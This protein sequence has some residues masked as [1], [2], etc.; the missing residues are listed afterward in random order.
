[1]LSGVR[2]KWRS[3]AKIKSHTAAAAAESE[4]T[5]NIPKIKPSENI[6]LG[7]PLPKAFSAKRIIFFALF[8]IA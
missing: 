4:F 8:F 3:A 1:L 6:F 7:K 5:E 2:A